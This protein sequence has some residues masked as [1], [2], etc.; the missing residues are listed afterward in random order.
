MIQI[1]AILRSV[2]TRYAPLCVEYR[3]RSL[4]ACNGR[5]FPGRASTPDLD[6]FSPF[7][8]GYRYLAYL[9]AKN[10]HAIKEGLPG[11]CGPE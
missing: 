7:P 10:G 1:I 11:L 5:L 9:Q 6:L 8:E 2:R 4:W 3:R